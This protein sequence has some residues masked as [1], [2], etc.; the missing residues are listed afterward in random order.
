MN[1]RTSL[2]AHELIELGRR[3]PPARWAPRIKPGSLGGWHKTDAESTRR[4][5]LKALLKKEPC[6]AVLRRI[7]MIANLTTD[8]PTETMLRADYKWVKKNNACKL[9][10]K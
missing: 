7:N 10:S 8:R 1:T 2:G 3:V 4:S 5:K 9:K 6:V